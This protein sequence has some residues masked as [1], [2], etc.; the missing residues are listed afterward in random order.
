MTM[1]TNGDDGNDGNDGDDAGDYEWLREE[2]KH[3]TFM[4]TGVEEMQMV[5]AWHGGI[6]LTALVWRLPSVR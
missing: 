1:R 5:S 4:I 2:T 6:P 3:W